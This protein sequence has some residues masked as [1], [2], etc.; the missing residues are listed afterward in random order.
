MAE[1]TGPLAGVRVIDASTL[2][3]GP[4]AAMFLGDLGADVVKIEHPARPDAARTHGPARN[5]VGLWW[6]TLGRNKRAA[7]LDLS[8][9]EG[10]VL[11]L[12]LAER[13]D[14]L[15]EN[16][17]PGTLERWGLGPDELHAANPRLVISRVTAFG[18]FGPLA[19][20]PGFGSIAEAMSGFAAITGE[21]DGPPTLPPLGLADGIAALA[22]SFAVTAALRSAEAT[23]RGQ[24]V[25]VAIIEPILM[26]L[27]AQITTYDQLGQLQ[28]RLGNRSANNAPRNVY[29]TA[30]GEWVAVSTS[31]QSIADRV[32][33]LVG[34]PDLVEQPWF[35]TGRQRAEHADELDDAVAAWIAARPT[36]DVLAAFEAAEAA[37][38]PVYD[39]R[40]VMSDPQYAA[41]GTVRTVE[42]EELGPVKMQNVLARLSATPGS[43]RWAGRPH[44]ADTSGVLAEIG[45]DAAEL[46]ELREKGIV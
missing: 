18:Q 42:D 43:I 41:L 27:G 10:A 36:A 34:R 1:P 29:R 46:A 6:K 32:I 35:A 28:Q 37:I 24:V 2:F 31:S 8:R 21:P 40:G 26:L 15:I 11:L 33:R 25:D 5:G 19:K 3:A 30:D 4:M 9:P 13:A 17:R 7:T 14:V 22:T 20:Q 12:R 38:G 23:G 39:V 16:F 45:V 44:G